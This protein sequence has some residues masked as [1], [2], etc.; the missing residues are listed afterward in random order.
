MTDPGVPAATPRAHVQ[1][2][3]E[4]DVARVIGM[5]THFCTR[6]GLPPLLAAHVA[7]A[8]SELAHNLWMHADRGGR[9]EITLV[10][11]ASGAGVELLARDDGPGI[12]D[13]DRA[14]T[15]GFSTLGGLG[16][17]LPGVRRLMDEFA[18]ESAPGRGTLVVAR[19]WV[20][21]R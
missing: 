20:A 9:I 19:K 4:H 18:I 7:T 16:C 17:G 6:H 2:D 5:V 21:R 11:R 13:V 3:G 15:D 1:V 12:A 14:M 10:R 8:A